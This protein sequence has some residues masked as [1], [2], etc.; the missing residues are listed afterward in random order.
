M[1]K[2]TGKYKVPHPTKPLTTRAKAKGIPIPTFVDD[3]GIPTL[4]G[5]RRLKDVDFPTFK[6]LNIGTLKGP[7][8][9]QLA[10]VKYIRDM[11]NSVGGPKRLSRKWRAYYDLPLL[12]NRRELADYIRYI[13]RMKHR[14][15]LPGMYSRKAIAEM[16]PEGYKEMLKRRTFTRNNLIKDQLKRS[17]LIRS[18]FADQIIGP[19]KRGKGENI[20]WFW[21]YSKILL[22][23]KNPELN[24]LRKDSNNKAYKEFLKKAMINAAKEW[25]ATHKPAGLS[26]GWY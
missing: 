25:E 17:S 19:T 12:S 3:K 16:T 1:P 22:S 21:D 7:Q 24:K 11:A 20:P 15:M 26:H 10:Y 9:T 5:G 8:A 13:T 4:T 18:V 2:V 14:R 23:S 6:D